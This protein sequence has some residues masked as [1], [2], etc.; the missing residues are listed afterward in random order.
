MTPEVNPQG[1]RVFLPQLSAIDTDVGTASITYTDRLDRPSNISE[2]RIAD[3]VSSC[4]C[5]GSLYS[6]HIPYPSIGKPADSPP[7]QQSL[8]KFLG[9]NV[10][11]REKATACQ[12]IAM[13]D[14]AIAE[15]P[16][17]SFRRKAWVEDDAVADEPQSSGGK[18]SPPCLFHCIPPD[19][20]LDETCQC[21]RGRMTSSTGRLP[22]QFPAAGTNANKIATR[23]ESL[24]S[25]LYSFSERH[26]C[27]DGTREECCCGRF[28][29]K[30]EPASPTA[31]ATPV[32]STSAEAVTA[33][34]YGSRYSKL[35]VSRA[36]MEAWEAAETWAW[37]IAEATSSTISGG[38]KF[39]PEARS[40]CDD[41][42]VLASRVIESSEGHCVANVKDLAESGCCC[43]LTDRIP[44]STFPTRDGLPHCSPARGDVIRA[45]KCFCVVDRVIP[46]LSHQYS[47]GISHNAV[48]AAI[49]APLAEETLEEGKHISMK[50]ISFGRMGMVNAAAARV[51]G[52]LEHGEKAWRKNAQCA[53]FRAFQ[54]HLL[55]IVQRRRKGAI[56]VKHCKRGYMA[57][58]WRSM[59]AQ[60]RRKSRS[61]GIFNA[62]AAAGEAAISTTDRFIRARRIRR[63]IAMFRR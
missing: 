3:E 11:W 9:D 7:C 38:E 27:A 16:Q 62:A 53:G 45:A 17:S 29:Q 60:I 49:K 43:S 25:N 52:R 42:Q 41:A 23:D 1:I 5:R 4:R 58:G 37:T 2:T 20:S 44:R 19:N 63:V 59:K 32:A 31:W 54:A 21:H 48:N 28:L 61:G 57:Q 15:T 36:A 46:I 22:I 40:V 51:L 13:S 35:A 39:S 10:R 50:T 26:Q 47:L 56:A 30:D 33:P 18:C 24:V 6:C 34:V 55:K 8:R 14:E 12:P